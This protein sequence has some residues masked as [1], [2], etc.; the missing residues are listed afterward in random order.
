MLPPA[1]KG[2]SQDT[3]QHALETCHNLG[4]VMSSQTCERKCS[5]SSSEEDAP[6]CTSSAAQDELIRGEGVCSD[7]LACASTGQ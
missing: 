1:G 4:P 7:A 6:G 3:V 5:S 2:L